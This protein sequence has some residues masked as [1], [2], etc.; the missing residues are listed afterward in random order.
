[1]N[2][3]QD[4]L[5]CVDIFDRPVGTATKEEAHRRGLLHR[6]FS[7]FIVEP[8]KKRML[9]QKRAAGKYH[10][11][12]LWANACCSHPRQ[13]EETLEAAHRRLLEEVGID[14]PLA[15]LYSFVYREVFS[16][17][18]VEYEYDHVFLGLC[19]AHELSLQPDPE[20]IEQ[21]A[22]I[23]LDLLAQSLQHQPETF[24]DWFLI[25]APRVLAFLHEKEEADPLI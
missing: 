19:P 25:C 3:N 5:I 21:M 13:G 10:S 23:D 7:V 11:S 9:L 14:C 12:G 4:Q 24:A 18:L 1:M 20:E 17:G 6:A 8:V 15:P 16:D 22:W 2:V